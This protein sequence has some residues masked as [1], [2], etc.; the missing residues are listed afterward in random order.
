MEDYVHGS[1][2][3]ASEVEAQLTLHHVWHYL[4]T[5]TVV[6][7]LNKILTTGVNAITGFTE[8]IKFWERKGS[9]SPQVS[10]VPSP[11]WDGQKVYFECDDYT[12]LLL[13]LNTVRRPPSL[14]SWALLNALHGIINSKV[15][16]YRGMSLDNVINRRL[17]VEG[18]QF[19]DREDGQPFASIYD[20]WD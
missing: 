19:L 7:G 2:T 5:V 4:D 6:K 9:P 8:P 20:Y 11:H 1:I 17:K 18:T 13:T 14:A 10:W 15:N 3:I 12:V 16:L